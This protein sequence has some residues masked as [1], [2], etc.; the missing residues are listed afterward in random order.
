MD[1]NKEQE[2]RQEE[3]NRLE[4]ERTREYYNRIEEEEWKKEQERIQE[5]AQQRLIEEQQ[6]QEQQQQQQEQQRR[7]S[8]DKQEQEPLVLYK[9]KDGMYYDK[10]GYRYKVERDHEQNRDIAYVDLKQR[11]HIRPD[12]P[13]LDLKPKGAPPRTKEFDPAYDKDGNYDKVEIKERERD[14]DSEWDRD[15]D[16]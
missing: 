11:G 15:R 2:Q 10:D 16:R 6:Q 14:R 5:R 1:N 3:Q 13:T 8:R 12:D 9:G 4:Q 7:E